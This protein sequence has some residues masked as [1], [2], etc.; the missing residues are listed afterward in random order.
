MNPVKIAHVVLTRQLDGLI[1]FA[2]KIGAREFVIVAHTTLNRRR[3]AHPRL[4][5]LHH[6]IA[7]TGVV[8]LFRPPQTFQCEQAHFVGSD[9][10][11]TRTQAC[12]TA[13]SE[14]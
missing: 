6:E 11:D 4:R 13:R 10:D 2:S 3:G 7:V 12:L 1:Q 8:G 9:H 14:I 5:D